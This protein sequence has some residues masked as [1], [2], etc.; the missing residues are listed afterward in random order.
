MSY[1]MV[2]LSAAW[3]MLE[4]GFPVT[5]RADF[6]LGAAAPDAIHYRPGDYTSDWKL[7]SHYGCENLEEIDEKWGY[8]TKMKPWVDRVCRLA[9]AVDPAAPDASFRMGY[10]VHILTDGWNNIRVWT[11][12]RESLGGTFDRE[13]YKLYGEECRNVDYVLYLRHPHAA[14]IF[15]L[16]EEARA[17]GLD[18]H[19]REEEVEALRDSL[20]HERFAPRPVPDVSGNRYFRLEEAEG[21]I[22]D[23]A[24]YTW[25]KLKNLPPPALQNA[26]KG[27]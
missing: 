1:P 27:I 24:A 2:H 21:F 5:S 17:F 12:F 3:L 6:M 8:V 26:E 7:Y 16:L 20:L 9:Q 23:A 18:D 22:R 19:I 13:T 25:E 10:Y 11:P 4:Q 14:E 15:R